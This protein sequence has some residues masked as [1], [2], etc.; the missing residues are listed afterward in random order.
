MEKD[1][2]KLLGPLEFSDETH[3]NMQQTMSEMVKAEL[4][5]TNAAENGML[6][7][8]KSIQ[9][10]LENEHLNKWRDK[11]ENEEA[12]KM[13]LEIMPPLLHTQEVKQNIK[14]F[15]EASHRE[16]KN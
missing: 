1:L 9:Q 14:R 4:E 16:K 7:I 13:Y 11:K 15:Q 12:K 8:C 10:E 5:L 6:T 2:E 3:G